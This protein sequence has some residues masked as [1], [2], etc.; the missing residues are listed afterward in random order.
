MYRDMKDRNE[1][2][3]IHTSNGFT[4]ERAK[5]TKTLFDTY[6]AEKWNVE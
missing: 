3:G 1:I 5:K 2:M 6:M 4:I